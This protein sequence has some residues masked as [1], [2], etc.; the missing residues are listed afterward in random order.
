MAASARRDHVGAIRAFEQA[1]RLAPDNP[2]PAARLALE[3]QVHGDIVGA[4]RDVRAA[5][6]LPGLDARTLDLLGHILSRTSDFEEAVELF[7]QAAAMAPEDIGILNNLAWGTQ[8]VGAFA[9]ADAALRKVLVL[10]PADHRAWFSL[11]GL[12]DWRPSAGEI[13]TLSG[14]L[15]AAGGDEERSLRLG[16]ALARA[17][18][19]LGDAPAALATLERAKAPRRRARRFDI[20]GALAAFDAAPKAWANG[21]TGPGNPSEAPIFIV[22]PPRSGTTLLDRILSS[23]SAVT[24]AGELRAMPLIALWVAR[25]QGDRAPSADVLLRAAG[26]SA[27][28]I[29]RTY[30]EAAA[31]LAGTTSR[32]TD[33]QPFNLIFAGLI[34]RTFPNAR[35]LR[36]RRAP[37]DTVLG[38]YRQLFNADSVFHDYAY[39]L[40]HTARYVAGLEALSQAWEERLPVDRYR[41]IDYEALVADPKGQIRAALDFCGLPWDP[42]CLE[43]HRNSAGVST[44]SAVQVREP[45][46]DR[47]IGLWRRYGAGFKPALEILREAGLQA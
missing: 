6:R 33:K 21:P 46:H 12:P 16:H 1:V 40:E 34:A 42:A 30:L 43:F 47:N 27:E 17:Q 15:E 3:R 18:E 5:R 39:D 24:S 28:L 36:M 44:A 38:N 9:E 8:H 32:F 13:N 2:T 35:I 25:V 37:A 29:G 41:V 4:R 10:E 45:L 14:L 31:S 23:H 26:A 20:D 11:S 19:A 7:R 22:G